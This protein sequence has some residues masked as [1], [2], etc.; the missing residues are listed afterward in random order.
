MGFALRFLRVT[1][2]LRVSWTF[3]WA[4]VADRAAY[5]A[6][7]R[8]ALVELAPSRMIGSH[9]DAVAS[10]TLADDLVRAIDAALG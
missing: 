10:P 9:G 6:W 4:G 3:R 2:G 1:P 5:R 8:Q 7:A